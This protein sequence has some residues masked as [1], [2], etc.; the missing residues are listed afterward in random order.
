M[1]LYSMLYIHVLPRV[2]PQSWGLL[3][4]K[5]NPQ[6][7]LWPSA[8]DSLPTP[9]YSSVYFLWGE[10]GQHILELDCMWLR[11]RSRRPLYQNIIV[12]VPYPP[13]RARQNNNSNW[14]NFQKNF[15]KFLNIYN[16]RNL[17]WLFILTGQCIKLW[18]NF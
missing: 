16:V 4:L 14:E 11:T 2:S 15:Q 10:T 9:F 5:S 1:K 7:I 13:K 17:K 18:L 12:S 3:V 6:S 8:L